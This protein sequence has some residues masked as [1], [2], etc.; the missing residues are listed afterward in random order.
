MH[1]FEVF[2]GC[3]DICNRDVKARWLNACVE[4]EV[5]FSFDLRLD[6]QFAHCRCRP[7]LFSFGHSQVAAV[8]WNTQSRSIANMACLNVRKYIGLLFWFVCCVA[9]RCGGMACSRKC[10]SAF[11]L[12]LASVRFG[13]LRR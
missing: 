4:F 5:F 8:S 2:R 10:M 9:T 6:F 7:S 1:D 11:R 13:S 12:M 3:F